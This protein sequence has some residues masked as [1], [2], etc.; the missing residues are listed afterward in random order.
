MLQRMSKGP[1][2][3]GGGRNMVHVVMGDH[4]MVRVTMIRR[5]RC[6]GGDRNM[7]HVAMGDRN[8]VHVAMI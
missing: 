5:S 4:N 2:R 6:A 3:A 7:A 8:M 1:R